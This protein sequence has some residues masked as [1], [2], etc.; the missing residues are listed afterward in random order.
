MSDPV[1]LIEDDADIRMLAELSLRMHDIP[2]VVACDGA[3]GLR[4]LQSGRFS[5]IITDVMMPDMSGY[6]V[7]RRIRDGLVAS[8]PPIALF[9]ARPQNDDLQEIGTG[10]PLPVLPKPFDP[11]DLARRVKLLMRSE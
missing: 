11:D 10:D 6:E 7:V 4:A 5:L 8:P 2:V 3:S 1:L 9:T